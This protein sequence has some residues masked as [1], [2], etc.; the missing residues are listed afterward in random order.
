MDS[1][2][3]KV[4]LSSHLGKEL[5]A[6][7]LGHKHIH[8]GHKTGATHDIVDVALPTN[9]TKHTKNMIEKRQRK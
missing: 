2:G 4:N 9:G 8:D 1:L 6:H 5:F 7:A 3:Q